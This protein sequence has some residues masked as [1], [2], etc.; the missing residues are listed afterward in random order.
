MAADGV[1]Q[2]RGKNYSVYEFTGKVAH[3]NKQLETVVS[4]GGGGGATYQGTGGSAPVSIR[5]TTYTHDDIFL[6]N[7]E[8]Q[9][10]VIRLLDWNIA[11]REGHEIQ[12]IWLI[13]QGKDTGPY[14]I[15]NNLT[16]N[17]VQ[18]SDKKL[19]ELLRLEWWRIFVVPIAILILGGIILGWIVIFAV[20]A[21]FYFGV[22]KPWKDDIQSAKEQLKP[23]IQSA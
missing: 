22:H 14:I 23:F 3:S 12:A 13:K 1:I 9:E 2:V 6:V 15:I 18:W 11:T 20:I 5:S 17:T 4:G 19:G 21:Y 16:T 8:G 7:T 10:Q